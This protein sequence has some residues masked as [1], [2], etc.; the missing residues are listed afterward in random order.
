MKLL[1]AA[2]LMLLAS[3]VHE[4]AICK[5]V[6]FFVTKDHKLRPVLPIEFT[7]VQESGGIID[8][9]LITCEVVARHMGLS[10]EAS[11]RDAVVTILKC[12]NRTLAIA[13][14]NFTPTR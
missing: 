4:K 5:N 12:G 13:T 10:N 6:Q 14:V 1:L 3:P 8:D 9:Q 7:V 11:P 2:T